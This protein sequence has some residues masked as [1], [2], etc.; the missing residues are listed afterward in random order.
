MEKNLRVDYGNNIHVGEN[1]YANFDCMILD[2]SPVVIGNNVVVV[3]SG[4]VVTKSFG[5]NVVIGGNPARILK[6]L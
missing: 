2:V 1:F 6:Q 3:A 4:L 5:D